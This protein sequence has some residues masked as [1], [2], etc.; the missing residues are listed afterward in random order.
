GDD[1]E[2]ISV[3]SDDAT[4]AVVG[5]TITINNLEVTV[6]KKIA[7]TAQMNRD[8]AIMSQSDFDSCI[9]GTENSKYFGAVVSTET[10]SMVEPIQEVER[11]A[12]EANL[13]LVSQDM[14]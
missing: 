4:P 3:I 10:D 11:T 5:D 14:F 1:C 8:V 12:D 13:S 9:I 7:N 6:A 2:G